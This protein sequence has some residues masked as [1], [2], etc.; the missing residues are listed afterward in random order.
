M[1][2]PCE[3]CL[4]V[5]ICRNKPYFKLRNDCENVNKFLMKYSNEYWEAKGSLF[6]Y[7]KPIKDGWEVIKI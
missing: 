6:K 2:I 1:K 4:C 3:G 7:L 5:P